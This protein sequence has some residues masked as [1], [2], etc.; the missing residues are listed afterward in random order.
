MFHTQEQKLVLEFQEWTGGLLWWWLLKH[1]HKHIIMVSP[2]I[3]VLKIASAIIQR[4]IGCFE[5]F[6]FFFFLLR[7]W[8]SL[9]ISSL[10]M[11]LTSS[12]SPSSLLYQP[13]CTMVTQVLYAF[14]S[15]SNYMMRHLLSGFI[16]F[17]S[18]ACWQQGLHLLYFPNT[19]P[20]IKISIFFHN[21]RLRTFQ[22]SLKL[23]SL[24]ASSSSVD[25]LH[26]AALTTC[27]TYVT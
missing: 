11:V 2:E 20:M 25:P 13:Q 14:F 26:L 4:R 27:P 22:Y 24:P 16:S 18:Q 6:T 3:D 8:S 21:V 9:L 10:I 7:H 23:V 12:P 19:Q 17:M 1:T 15:T 5:T